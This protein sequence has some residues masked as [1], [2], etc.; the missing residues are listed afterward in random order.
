MMQMFAVAL[1][2]ALGA[3]GRYWVSGLFNNAAYKLP[4]GTLTVNVLGSFLMGV[5]FVLILERTRLPAELRPL[6]MVGF[7]GAFTTFST[8][9]LETVALIGEG[10]VMSAL[11]YI[12]LSVLLCIAALGAGLWLTRLF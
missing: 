3:M 9:S 8:F 12:L 6:L 11:I 7:L 10:H 5:C 1:G 4:L 2:G